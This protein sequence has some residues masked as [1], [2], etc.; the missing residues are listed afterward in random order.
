MN[1]D[2]ASRRLSIKHSHIA[3][4]PE[5]HL[6]DPL[7]SS[8]QFGANE[9]RIRQCAGTLPFGKYLDISS[10][11]WLE[12]ISDNVIDCESTDQYNYIYSEA[13]I[14]RVP[15]PIDEIPEA[16]VVYKAFQG[17]GRKYIALRLQKQ[18]D[19]SSKSE[20]ELLIFDFTSGTEK[21]C[22]HQFKLFGLKELVA[23]LLRSREEFL[24]CAT[25]TVDDKAQ[26][27]KVHSPELVPTSR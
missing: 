8:S 21:K 5:L 6:F 27:H 18:S 26:K 7:R 11:K 14:F 22:V 13:T 9:G 17:E 3:G 1:Y 4:A 20:H 10:T 16:D 19:R 25:K 15:L 12:M 24:A 23:G 2:R